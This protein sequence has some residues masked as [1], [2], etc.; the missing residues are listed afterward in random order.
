[1]S[2]SDLLFSQSFESRRSL[3]ISTSATKTWKAGH[4]KFSPFL[5][6][7]K[8]LIKVNRYGNLLTNKLKPRYEGPYKITKV[9]SNK[10]TYELEAIHKPDVRKKKAHYLQLRPFYEVPSY[11]EQLQAHQER[12]YASDEGTSSS[13][14]SVF[15]GFHSERLSTHDCTKESDTDKIQSH[16]HSNR[17]ED[18]AVAGS[19]TSSDKPS[20]REQENQV[21]DEIGSQSRKRSS[22]GDAL[23]ELIEQ[24]CGVAHNSSIKNL[25]D[26]PCSEKSFS[27]IASTP[28]N[29]ALPGLSFGSLSSIQQAKISY[30]SGQ[31][32]HL[33]SS[34]T[35]PQ[36]Q[37]YFV[38]ELE[39]EN[40]ISFLE[41]NEGSL[42][43]SVKMIENE[44]NNCNCVVTP[45]EGEN[46][47]EGW[48]SVDS[49]RIIGSAKL[50]FLNALSRRTRDLRDSTAEI[51]LRIGRVRE[52][53]LREK[54]VQNSPTIS[55][56]DFSIVPVL[57]FD[58]ST[59][60]TR[61]RSK[62]KVREYPNVQPRT[63]EYK[64]TKK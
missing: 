42:N 28:I 33:K 2:P 43:E 17:L 22:L 50:N 51:R 16:E 25:E 5:I 3:P 32:S 63:L 30:A 45:L 64:H 38:S 10:L 44:I 59:P 37:G 62:G 31:A 6:D 18:F 48:G 53:M 1:M 20:E 21:S 13:D 36:N 14:E 11:L 58:K 61:T 29:F 49:D 9:Q 8:V 40:I 19:Q 27:W 60:V 41:F 35:S 23:S 39:L 56:V 12:F 52:L 4:P 55:E 34:S 24:S 46:V 57:D 26:L 47:F 15:L 54:L 7:Q